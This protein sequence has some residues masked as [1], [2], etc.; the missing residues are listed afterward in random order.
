M[1]GA[2]GPTAFSLPQRPDARLAGSMQVLL[3]HLDVIDASANGDFPLFSPGVSQQ[4]QSSKGGSWVGGFWA[5]CFWLRAALIK[6]C[7]VRMPLFA[8]TTKMAGA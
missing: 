3:D 8:F 7:K 6:S 5:G 1:T 2:G 4:W